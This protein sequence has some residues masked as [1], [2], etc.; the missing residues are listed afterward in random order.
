MQKL[1]NVGGGNLQ[2]YI[3]CQM[4]RDVFHQDLFGTLA[5]TASGEMD[6]DAAW[7]MLSMHF[8]AS[9]GLGLLE[10]RWNHG[11]VGRAWGMA[12]KGKALHHHVLASKHTTT[13]DTPIS[14]AK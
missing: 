2:I 9:P 5:S 11:F 12:F 10:T 6:L 1:L 8:S 7:A 13:V 3:F 4:N 14:L